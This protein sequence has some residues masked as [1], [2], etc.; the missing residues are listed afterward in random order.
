MLRCLDVSTVTA[1]GCKTL[2]PSKKG[3][4]CQSMRE[5]SK[6]LWGCPRAILQSGL[7]SEI[8][9]NGYSMV[10]QDSNVVFSS[11]FTKNGKW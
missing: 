4:I 5:A 2:T 6:Y 7:G 1:T 11:C 10:W 9:S 8:I 3:D